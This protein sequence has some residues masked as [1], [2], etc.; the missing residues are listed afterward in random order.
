MQSDEEAIR[1]TSR[2]NKYRMIS[3]LLS[4]RQQ[5]QW[6]CIARPALWLR[7]AKWTCHGRLFF[8]LSGLLLPIQ[9]GWLKNTGWLGQ[10]LTDRVQLDRCPANVSSNL[11]EEYS[12]SKPPERFGVKKAYSLTPYLHHMSRL[13]EGG[14]CSIYRSSP[15]DDR[16]RTERCSLSCDY[17]VSLWMV[18]PVIGVRMMTWSLKVVRRLEKI[19]TCTANSP[20]AIYILKAHFSMSE[21]QSSSMTR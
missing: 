21:A 15:E 19:H 12:L 3:Y 18:A 11:D 13:N 9:S 7:G 1:Q 2:Q 16:A 8:D 5:S 20:F 14:H 4:P 17:S 6:H 10:A